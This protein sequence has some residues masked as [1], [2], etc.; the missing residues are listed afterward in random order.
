MSK[1]Q[2]IQAL[3]ERLSALREQRDKLETEAK[4]FA[5]KRDKLNEQ[6]KKARAE[7][8]ELRSK[9]DEL[10]ATVKELKQQRSDMKTKI[11]ERIESAKELRAQVGE[12]MKERPEGSI[13]ALQK[14]IE[15]IDWKIQTSSLSQQEE[16]ELV[17]RVKELGKQ[18]AA[19][20]KIARIREKHQKTQAEITSLKATG[21]QFHGTLTNSAQKSQGTHQKML[22]KIEETKKLEAEADSAHQTF[23]QARE[24]AGPIQDEITTVTIQIRQLKG[25]IREDEAKERKETEGALREELEKRAK[26]KLAR[27]EK[28]TW[29]EFQMLQG[30]DEAQD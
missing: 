13:P 25:E 16:K 17:A 30:E 28:M 20:K 9:R 18:L 19:H 24:K 29:D 11:G 5:E 2:K 14:Q 10:N 26:E 7:I 4:E 23:V 12:L 22:E 15:E 1:Q 6:S 27:G 8:A 3:T 21:E